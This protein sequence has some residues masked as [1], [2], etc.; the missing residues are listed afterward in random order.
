LDKNGEETVEVM[1]ESIT[2]AEKGVVTLLNK[3]RHP[4]E[5]GEAVRITG[6]KGMTKQNGESINGTIHKIIVINQFSFEI[7]N[8]LEYS[9]YEIDG[10]AR[11]MKL[12]IKV[13]FKP[14][15]ESLKL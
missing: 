7:G 15:E 3:Q 14:L 5:D 12:P 2:N 10:V 8:T 13:E 1:I 9:S 4:Y 6:V 11:N